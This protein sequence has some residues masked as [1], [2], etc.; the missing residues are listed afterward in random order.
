[1]IMAYFPSYKLLYGAD[2]VA[3]N[4][5]VA[6]G[7]PTFDETEAA[8]LRAAV[9]REKLAVDSV[10]SVQNDPHPFAWSDFVRQ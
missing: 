10:F 8:D 7:A 2:L 5:G 3:V 4:R 6:K 1:M 9:A